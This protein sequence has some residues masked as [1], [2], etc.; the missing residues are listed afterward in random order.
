MV[1]TRG[2]QQSSAIQ[3]PTVVESATA[4][5]SVHSVGKLL[6]C[7]LWTL[8]RTPSCGSTELYSRLVCS[9][10]KKRLT[11]MLYFRINVGATPKV[12]T[13]V[14]PE[15]GHDATL[16]APHE[17][18]VG[19]IG[20]RLRKR[21]R[22]GSSP[23]EST[24]SKRPNTRQ[25][26]SPDSKR[27]SHLEIQPRES[28]VAPPQPTMNG[29]QKHVSEIERHSPKPAMQPAQPATLPPASSSA[30]DLA[31]VIANIIDHGEH[32]DN[33][34][35]AQGYGSDGLAV[36]TEDWLSVDASLHLKIQSL[37]ILDNLV[38]WEDLRC[39]RTALTLLGSRP[40]S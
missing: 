16:T 25:T 39:W 2:S 9:F 29:T 31:A 37:P 14:N 27:N 30:P 12:M 32:V 24:P 13:C 33:H 15:T 17:D 34:W 1:T 7:F 11:G 6:C 3:G 18:E 20:S 35:A 40:K 10:G 21:R 19:T 8:F 28:P 36:D 4:V 38:G 5:L 23:V 22:T 26:T